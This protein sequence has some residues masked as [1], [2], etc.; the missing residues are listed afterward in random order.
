MAKSAKHN[1]QEVIEKATNLYWE[2]GFHA[3]SMRN[4]QEVVDLR[5]GSIYASFGSKEGLFK[6]SLEHYANLNIAAVRAIREQAESPI[7]ALQQVVQAIVL[8]SRES[9]PSGMC[10]LVK[11]V[12]ELTGEHDELLEDAK[13]WLKL[14]EQELVAIIEEGIAAEQLSADKGAQRIARF[15]QVQLMGLRTYGRVNSDKASVLQTIDDIFETL[16][17]WE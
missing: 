7:D 15:L 16:T 2:K 9:A 5:P 17:G 13:K 12:A 14:M 1:R 11:T 8:D 3:T 4:L 10:M 6:E